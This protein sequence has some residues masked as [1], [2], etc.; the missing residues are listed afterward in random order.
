M[1]FLPDTTYPG[2]ASSRRG[3]C[4]FL[5]ARRS[6]LVAGIAVLLSLG[7][8]GLAPLTFSNKQEISQLS[9]TVDALKVNQDNMRQLSATVD[10]LKRDQDALKRDQD[11]LKRDQDE[12]T[13]DQDE[14]KCDQND[15]RQ[16]SAT[17]DILKRD[18]DALKRDQDA[19]KRDQDEVK[20][21]QDEVK[22]DQDDIRQLSATVD[23][24]KRDQ[25]A[26]K[27]DQDAMKRDQDDVKGDQDDMRQLLTTV[28][29]LKRDQDALKRNQDALK[30]DQDNMKRNRDDVKGDQDDMRQLSTTVDALKRDQDALK[31]NQDA[32]KCDQDDMRRLSTT[33]EALKCVLY[34]E[35]KQ[36]A[37]L[38][39]RLHEIKQTLPSCPEGYTMWRGTCFKAFDTSKTFSGAANACGADGGTLAMPQDAET[40]TFLASLSKSVSH[41]RA[42]WFGL[43]DRREEGRFQWMDGSAL[44]SYRSWAPGQPDSHDGNEDCVLYPTSQKDKWHDRNCHQ[45]AYFICQAAPERP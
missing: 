27:R 31:R 20:R 9:T 12:V 23:V 34:K 21:D 37:T 45:R 1:F 24:L 8:I 14:V 28:D 5:R 36:T 19:L 25:D 7:V 17:V 35:R 39:K 6:F 2:G 32:L 15:I 10:A 43:H 22:C 40:N 18:Q 38:E 13:R 11:A 44:G 30:R 26:L 33:V 42:F 41:I 29:A 16:L 3:V 4:S